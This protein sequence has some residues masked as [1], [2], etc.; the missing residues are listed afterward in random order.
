MVL[1]C[2]EMHGFV[3]AFACELPETISTM[4]DILFHMKEVADDKAS[5]DVSGAASSQEVIN[6]LRENLS[7]DPSKFEKLFWDV[8]GACAISEYSVSDS[9]V[10]IQAL[11]LGAF[12]LD[13]DDLAAH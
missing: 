8:T 7:T 1:S 10:S 5:G 9:D 3:A 13:F 11:F 6:F 4:S 12:P 2:S